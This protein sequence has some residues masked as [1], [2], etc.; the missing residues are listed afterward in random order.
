MYHVI[1][2]VTSY[3]AIT[4]CIYIKMD[5]EMPN[6]PGV[7]HPNVIKSLINYNSICYIT[8]KLLATYV[9]MRNFQQS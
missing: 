1:F 9:L 2:K 4:T 5:D 6:A 8:T 3:I 7:D